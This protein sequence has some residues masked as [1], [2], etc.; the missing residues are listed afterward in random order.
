[1]YE[2]FI[3]IS[4]PVYPG[5]FRK[6]R[7]Y[8]DY[9]QSGAEQAKGGVF[10]RVCWTAPDDSRAERLREAIGRDRQ[11]LAGLFVVTTSQRALRSLTALDHN[12]DQP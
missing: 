5:A 8:A 11:L 10:P 9:Y 3:R 12:H 7:L 1:M 6:C 4:M 2:P